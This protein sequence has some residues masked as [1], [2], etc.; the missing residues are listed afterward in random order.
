MQAMAWA[1]L[2]FVSNLTEEARDMVLI[3]W[4]VCTR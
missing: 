1:E 2:L 3:A 4:E